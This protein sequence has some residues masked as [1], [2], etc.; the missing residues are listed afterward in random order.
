MRH[1]GAIADLWTLRVY[2]SNFLFPRLYQGSIGAK[3][4]IR[5]ISQD[6]VRATRERKVLR[7]SCGLVF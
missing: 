5:R 4:P 3:P 6:Q 7:R 2:T 1:F